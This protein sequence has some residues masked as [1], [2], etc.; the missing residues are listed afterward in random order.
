MMKKIIFVSFILFLFL[1][2]A[3]LFSK[4][5]AKSLYVRTDKSYVLPG[6]FY[7]LTVLSSR[8]PFAGY[9]GLLDVNVTSCDQSGNCNTTVGPWGNYE[10]KNGS[11]RIDIPANFAPSRF[12]ARFR[13]RG[14]NWDWSNEIQVNVGTTQDLENSQEYWLLTSPPT[15]FTVNNFVDNKTSQTMI[16]F[17]SPVNLCGETV[18]S[19]YFMKSD[20][21]GYWDPHVP[22]YDSIRSPGYD[23][24]NLMWHLAL[25]QKKSGW[26]DEYLTAL[27]H[28][29][30]QYNSAGP[31]NLGINFKVKTGQYRNKYPNYILSPKWVGDGWG[32]GG[33]VESYMASPDVPFCNISTAGSGRPG[34]WSVHVDRVHL[35]LPKYSGLALRYKFYEGG[36]NF[37]VDSSQL[38]LRED[39][40]FV[41]NMGL[42]KIDVKYFGPND[43]KYVVRKP[44]QEDDDCLMNE[45][46]K[47]PHVRLVRS[48]LLDTQVLVPSDLNNDGKVNIFDYNILI[49][50]FG[51]TGVAGFVKSDIN[52]DGKVDIFDYN[53][54]VGNFGK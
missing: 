51:K 6:G 9:S 14:S 48:D 39:W 28:E 43:A 13:P 37:V 21:S 1:F 18:Q 16:G 30:Y 50:D 5:Y 54:L 22:W 35:D 53:I 7:N 2:V 45:T 41:K 38:G 20:P 47:S 11:I 44:C 36:D 34:I 4:A 8:I 29:I 33:R 10:V 49:S 3:P 31:F 32:K 27:G 19:M 23:K 52:K 25:W 12:R 17:M 26:D 40:Y 24:L 15:K 46:M 42:V